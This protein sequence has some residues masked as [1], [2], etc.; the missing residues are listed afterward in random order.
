M[1]YFIVMGVTGCG[2]TTIAE[3]LAQQIN[4][5]F[6]EADDL[7][8]QANIKKMS[9]GQPLTDADRWPWLDQIGHAMLAAQGITIV[10]CSSLRRVYRDRIRSSVNAPVGFIH[11]VGQ[12]D[13][14]ANRMQARSEH[15]MPVSLLKSQLD[16]LEPLEP[17]EDGVEINIDLPVV[18][19]LSASKLYIETRLQSEHQ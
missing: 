12:Q 11:L 1:Q 16:L 18:D 13:V 14:I 8:S 17:D 6:I 7:H 4:G 10:S 5:L 3:G 15:F 19:V 2:K 9:A